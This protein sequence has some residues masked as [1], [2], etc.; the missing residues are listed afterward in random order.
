MKVEFGTDQRN[1]MKRG[2]V[3]AMLESGRYGGDVGRVECGVQS[4]EY[5]IW[6]TTA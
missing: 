5:R 3:K 6:R 4:M 2:E 1:R